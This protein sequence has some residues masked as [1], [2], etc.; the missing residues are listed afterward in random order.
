MNTPLNDEE[1]DR[2][3]RKRAGAKMGWYVHLMI[4]LVV[5]AGLIILSTQFGQHR[6]SIFPA[7]GWG[8]GLLFHGLSVFVLGSGS[9]L[10]ENMVQRE[11]ERLKRNKGQ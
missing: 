9:S 4:Y 8:V 11:R 3:A 5:N 6:W 7:V 1:I 2:L 10:R